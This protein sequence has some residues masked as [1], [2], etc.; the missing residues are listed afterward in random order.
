MAASKI[1]KR[2]K[3]T[4]TEYN[5]LID[6]NSAEAGEFKQFDGQPFE[7]AL[8]NVAASFSDAAATNLQNADRVASG[9]LLESIKPSEIK[10]SGNTMEIDIAVLD[11]YKFIDKGVK[12]WK[13]GNPS[14]SPYSFKQPEKGG[15]G[16]KSSAMV[17]A[18]RKWLIK[19]GMKSRQ[20]SRKSPTHAISSRERRRQKITDAAT[21]TAIKVAGIIRRQ[22]L[23]KTN[24]W[25]DAEKT[26]LKVAQDEFGTA[27]QISIINS[28]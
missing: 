11:Y 28:I 22:G 8:F 7:V 27:L 17:T 15:S 26:A 5:K 3:Y 16:K 18:I 19:E 13:S 1:T 6:L 21:S 2:K 14:D 25:T 10:I 23:K 20:L 12:G 9:D 24:F 4:E